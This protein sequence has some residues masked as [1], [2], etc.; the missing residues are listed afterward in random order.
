MASYQAVID[1]GVLGSQQVERVL[2]RV[3]HLRSALEKISKTPLA[4][5]DRRASDTF[6]QLATSAFNF[7]QG[8][9]QAKT[10]LASTTAAVNQQAAGFRQLAANAKIGGAAFNTFTQAAEQAR[11][12]ASLAG[13]AEIK[14]LN[15]LYGVGRTAP[16]QSFK[17]V[18]ELLALGKQ[19]PKNTASLSLYQAELQR[20]ID[21]VDYGTTEYRQLAQAI[22][23]VNKQMDI[24]RGAG[25]VQGPAALT[26]RGRGQRIP[27]VAGS[28]RSGRLQGIVENAVIGGAFPLLFGQGGGAAAGGAIGGLVGGAFGGAGGF[29]GS[30]LGTLIGDIVSQGAKIK[31]L[32]A[33]IGFSAQQTRQLQEAFKLAG[34][35]AEK[36]TEAVQNIRG[37]GLAIEDQAKAIQLVST[38]TEQFG[39]NITKT[40]N[41]LTGALE[42]GKVTQATLNQLTSQGITIQDALAAKYKT[43]RDNILVM[44]KD[45]KISVQDLLD[46]LV[47]LANKGSAGAPEV[48]SAY[49]IAFKTVSDKL[50]T[51]A[52]NVSAAFTTN[53]DEI[54]TA[55]ESVTAKATNGFSKIA[56]AIT[57]LTVKVAELIAKFIDLGTQAASALLSIPGYVETVANGVLLMIPGLQAVVNLLGTINALTGGGGRTAQETGMYGRYVPGSQQQAIKQPIGRIPALSQV[58]PSAK[59]GGAKRDRAAEQAQ[60]LAA[61]LKQLREEVSIRTRTLQIEENILRA[62][63]DQDDTALAELESDKRLLEIG[64]KRAKVQ[65]DFDAGR[66]QQA[67]YTLRLQ[68]IELDQLEDQIKSEAELNRIYRERFGLTDAIARAGREARERAFG[69]APGAAGG[70]GTFRTDIDLMPG[71]TGGMLGERFAEL[72]T[73]LEELTKV[74]NQ[75]IFGAQAIGDAFGTSLKGVISGTMTAQQA[76]ANF[77]QSVAD[78]FADMA[79]QMI[80]KWI[81]MQIIGLAQSLLPGGS[82]I[83]SQGVNNFSNFFGAAGPTFQPLAFGGGR[84]TGG[85]VMSGTSYMVGERGPE[86]FVPRSSGTI[87]PNHDLGGTT[88][89]VVNVDAKGSNVQGD[90]SQAKALGS[91]ISVAVQAE[92]V[93]QQRPGGLLAGTR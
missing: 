41:A 30:L 25:P 11:Q 46:T 92:I 57:P 12:K 16:T 3:E 91:A 81:Q 32:A 71:L 10:Q 36:F 45:G 54:N 63:A 52:S 88:N 48:Q 4:I 42:S 79:A 43:S 59:G 17:G 7:A 39:G 40:T 24:G 58:M 38:L 75:V 84:A 85:S 5:D 90:D 65:K 31:E 23:D 44:A 70:A 77:F 56:D 64:V 22:A 69:N 2:N 6:R 78:H 62:R 35:D 49:E 19:I 9:A 67:E 53:T 72:R 1:I 28:L 66:I 74:Q 47:D 20:V 87:I 76:L 8:L 33:D 61:L 14:A 60:R 80:A 13:L 21:I 93:K 26:G 73:E 82:T 37:V 55:L 68:L 50:Q 27:G 15:T 34:A 51:L 29:A 18:E 83:F 86:L 89:V